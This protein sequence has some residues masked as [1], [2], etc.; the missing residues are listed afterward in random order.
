[1]VKRCLVSR[2]FVVCGYLVASAGLY[3]L[4]VVGNKVR[5][6]P[7][8]PAK[9]FG[10][11]LA[12]TFIA[13]GP[14]YIKLGQI[15][16]SRPDLVDPQIANELSGLLDQ[17]PPIPFDQVRSAWREEFGLS[18]E[19]AFRFLERVPIASGSV[20][21][22]YRGRLRTGDLVAVKVRR[23]GIVTVVA[24]D[25]KLLRGAVQL[26]SIF[27]ALHY[28]PLRE[29]VDEVLNAIAEQ[30]DFRREADTSR[31]LRK[32]L[33]WEP[34]VVIPGVVDAFSGTT[35][36]TQEFVTE[37]A[38]RQLDASS[39]RRAA[40][41]AALRALY[42]MIFVE[43]LVHCDLHQG[44]LHLLSDGRA[45]ILDFGFVATLSNV[46]RL[47][48][49]EFFF[50]MTSGEGRRCAE[51]AVEMASYIPPSF[52]SACFVAEIARLVR[53]AHG[54]RA[55]EF[56]VA[57]FVSGMFDIQRRH[58]VRST[59]AFVLTVISLVVFEGL[60][61]QIDPQLDFQGLA[62][63]FIFR[64]FIRRSTPTYPISD[65]NLIDTQLDISPRT[66]GS[67]AVGTERA[68]RC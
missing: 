41:Q 20:A 62:Q 50:A 55:Q 42:R 60:I 36:L 8:P 1:M 21:S 46:D 61:K 32:A 4:R 54:R 30:L 39:G 51:I 2:A 29:V 11:V 6:E 23:P 15:L 56:K 53:V 44:N 18:V 14:T 28:L 58:R 22:V 68:S 38:D 57:D 25:S 12:R 16:A 33:V 13:L 66:I 59:T 9:I 52:N 67:Q 45:V 10:E 63:R 26:A 3:A 35:V 49:A 43:G 47:S 34:E 64:G 27:P 37:I 17:L 31:R 40:L 5:R 48:F 19:E 65:P 7:C 24:A